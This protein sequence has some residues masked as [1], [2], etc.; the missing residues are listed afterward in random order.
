MAAE[1]PLV[2]SLQKALA[3]MVTPFSVASSKKVEF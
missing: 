2:S 3:N 1:L